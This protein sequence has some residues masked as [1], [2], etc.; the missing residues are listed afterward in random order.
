M[1]WLEICADSPVSS[2]VTSVSHTAGDVMAKS[3]VTEL[4]MR[5]HANTSVP[6]RRIIDVPTLDSASTIV[7]CVTDHVTVRT[8]RMNETAEWVVV[9]GWEREGYP[10]FRKKQNQLSTTRRVTHCLVPWK[11]SATKS[12][13]QTRR[14]RMK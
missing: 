13:Q 5:Q 8:V 11:S 2:V 9:H 10:S 14:R 1:L 6:I 12:I 4:K 3:T 7:T